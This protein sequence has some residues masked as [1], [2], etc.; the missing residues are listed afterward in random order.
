MKGENDMS[1]AAKVKQDRQDSNAA[2][3]EE[4]SDPWELI[5]ASEAQVWEALDAAGYSPG[6]A[7]GVLEALRIM[8]GKV[9]PWSSRS[10]QQQA[11]LALVRAGLVNSLD[12]DPSGQ[13]AGF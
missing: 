4:L 3:L 8:D 2:I 10:V 5:N 9:L 7:A 6:E 13:A 12:E 1:A 11:S